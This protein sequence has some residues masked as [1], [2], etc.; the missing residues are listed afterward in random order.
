MVPS[1]YLSGGPLVSSALT[2]KL[3]ALLSS[4]C[5]H[6]WRRRPSTPWTMSST[7]SWRYEL[8][9]SSQVSERCWRCRLVRSG[10]PR[11]PDGS[12]SD[13]G[14][15]SPSHAIRADADPLARSATSVV[16]TLADKYTYDCPVRI[17]I[18]P[19]GRSKFTLSSV[20][21]CDI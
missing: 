16:I 11:L 12:D 8:L 6:C 15:E 5:L 10:S 3:R 1:Q 19:S 13:A 9:I 14:V 18:Y 20:L 21:E 4:G 17:L 7:S 2:S